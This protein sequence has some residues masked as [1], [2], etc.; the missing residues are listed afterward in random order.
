MMITKLGMWKTG[1]SIQIRLNSCNK[2]IKKKKEE[3][4][5][6]CVKAADHICHRDV[7]SNVLKVIHYN[8]L[9]YNG[10]FNVDKNYPDY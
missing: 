9:V 6:S 7:D 2:Q 1:P 10:R 8:V 4:I 3:S 5:S